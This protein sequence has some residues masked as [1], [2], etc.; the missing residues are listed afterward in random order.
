MTTPSTP[1]TLAPP[2]GVWVEQRLDGLQVR[3]PTAERSLLILAMHLFVKSSKVASFVAGWFIGAWSFTL[4]E[5]SP[6]GTLYG[7]V[8]MASL[9]LVLCLCLSL[10]SIWLLHA[11][12]KRIIADLQLRLY[13]TELIIS[14]HELS[15]RR[16]LQPA[17][18]IPSVTLSGVRQAADRRSVEVIL[19]DGSAVAIGRDQAPEILTWLELQLREHISSL[20]VRQGTAHEVP[21]ALQDLR[22]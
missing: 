6:L 15:L 11:V 3:L 20:R 7:G 19:N 12:G 17:Q 5:G 16:S 14:P 18:K 13:P 22:Q 4:I 9:V 8:T 10:L 21:R 1:S 2:E